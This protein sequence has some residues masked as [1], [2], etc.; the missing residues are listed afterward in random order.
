MFETKRFKI[1]HD[2][3]SI[4]VFLGSHEMRYYNE[5]KDDL[6]RRAFIAHEAWRK[7]F[8]SDAK[9]MLTRLCDQIGVTKAKKTFTDN[10][11][12]QEI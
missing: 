5:C 10:I 1:T 7:L 9:Q 8:D 2:I 4:E 6:E 3:G 12:I 11:R